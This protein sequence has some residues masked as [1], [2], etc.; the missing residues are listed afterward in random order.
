MTH[1]NNPQ[2]ITILSWILIIFGGFG[3]LISIGQNILV[4]FNF[5]VAVSTS[6]LSQNHTFIDLLFA[7]IRYIFI[8]VFIIAVITFISGIG[9]L[10]RQNW[11]RILSIILMFI[12]VLWNICGVIYQFVLF[13]S[14]SREFFG[15]ESDLSSFDVIAFIIRISTLVIAVLLSLLYIWIIKKTYVR[16]YQ[17]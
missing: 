14:I 4:S 12:G 17:I 9:L 8:F 15:S 1:S 3:S 10:K 7:N 11:G 16:T 6:T 2:F 13:P 5:P